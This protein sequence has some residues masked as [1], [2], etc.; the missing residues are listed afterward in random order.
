MAVNPL[1][2]IILRGSGALV[3]IIS[4]FIGWSVCSQHS[5]RGDGG[6]LIA[7]VRTSIPARSVGVGETRPGRERFSSDEEDEG[8]LVHVW[9]PV[10]RIK[11]QQTLCC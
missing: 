3:G 4:C 9:C 7:T 10:C 6:G 11:Q 2:D 1:N 8:P 5:G